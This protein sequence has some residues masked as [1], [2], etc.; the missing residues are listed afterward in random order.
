MRK[1]VLKL[2][3]YSVDGIIGVENTEFFD[4][5]RAL[6]DDPAQEAWVRS[7]LEAAAVHIMGRVT[8][9]GMAQYFPTAADH[10]Y[11]AARAILSTC[12]ARPFTMASLATSIA[13]AA[14]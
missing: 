2:S 11:A 7:F 1:V 5:C 12:Q 8:F 9:Q 13:A 10:P 4:F 6:P 3:D 14:S